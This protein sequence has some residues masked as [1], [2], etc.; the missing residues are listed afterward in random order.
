ML[1]HRN[2]VDI[3]VSKRTIQI[4]DFIGQNNLKVLL[5]PFRLPVNH[6]HC[7]RYYCELEL[8][9]PLGCVIVRDNQMGSLT[10]WFSEQPVIFHC[11]ILFPLST[12]Q[13]PKWIRLIGYCSEATP[14]CQQF[15]VCSQNI[16]PVEESYEHQSSVTV[17]SRQWD[18]TAVSFWV[19]IIGNTKSIIANTKP[20]EDRPKALISNN[21]GNIFFG[22][23]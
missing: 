10:A 20:I 15:A 23:D 2:V 7:A 1:E 5:K 8:A 12:G 13:L 11:C 19:N 4:G 18:S 3:V 21:I 14:R 16:S 9:D 17:S 22:L 6:N